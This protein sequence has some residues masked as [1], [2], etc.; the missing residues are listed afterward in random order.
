MTASLTGTNTPTP[1]KTLRPSFTPTITLTP[2]SPG[3]FVSFF[4]VP[5]VMRYDPLLWIDKSNYMEWGENQQPVAGVII[6]NYIQAQELETCIIGVQGPTDFNGTPPVFV[7]VRLGD[8]RYSVIFWGETQQGDMSAWYIEDQSLHG[9]DYAPGLP[10]LGVYA[11]L[12]EWEECKAL[13]EEV[14][15]TLHV[16]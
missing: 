4:Y 5:L 8:I 10:I 9:Y 3:V 11:N 12:S 7:P 14:L 13:A 15:A 1:T 2:V 16:P 6:E